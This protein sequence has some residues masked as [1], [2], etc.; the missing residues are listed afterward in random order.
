MDTKGR[1]SIP[2]LIRTEL[3]RHSPPDPILTMGPECLRLFT[4][5]GWEAY[6]GQIMD[7]NVFDPDAEAMRRFEISSSM[8][9]KVDAQ[10]RLLIPGWMREEAH[11]GREVVIAGMGGWLELWDKARFA[12]ENDRVRSNYREI[13]AALADRA[14]K[15]D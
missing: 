4:A 11:L 6:A 10:G 9:A 3:A 7:A 14:R 5:D 12:A 8:D 1:V 2:S 15:G 13:R